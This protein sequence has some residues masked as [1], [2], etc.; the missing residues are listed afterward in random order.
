MYNIYSINGLI[1]SGDYIMDKILDNYLYDAFANASDNIFIYVTD[2]SQDLTRWSKKAVDFFGLEGEY[3]HG[4]K[5]MWLNQIHPDDRQV[6]IDDITAVFNGKTAQHNCQYRVRSR[7]GEYVWVECRGSLILDEN[8]TPAVFAGIMTRLD[9]QNKYDALTHLLTGYELLRSVIDKSGAVLLVGIDQFR[10]FNTRYGI[11]N[12]NKVLT[13]LGKMISEAA[14][15]AT[16]FHFHGDEFV[17]FAKEKTAADLQAIF[18]KICKMCKE[19]EENEG[20][21]SISLS[22]GIVEF[23]AGSYISDV[24]EKAELSLAFAKDD[25]NHIIVYSDEIGAKQT[26]KNTISEN[27]LRCIKNDFEGFSLVYQPI[28]NN[29]GDRV[30]ACE[31]LLRWNTNNPDIGPCYPGEFIPIL[32]GNGGII[33]VGYFVMREAIKQASKWQKEYKKFNVSFNVSYAQ[34]EDPQF[35]PEIIKTSKEYGVDTTGIVVE[36]TESILA[37][38]TVMVKQ[39]FKLLKEQGIQIA[40]D[41]FGTGNSSFWMLHN[42]D[43]DIVKLDQSF[44]RGLDESG[45]GIDY[46]IVESVG[47]MC[48]RI[49]CKTVAEGIETQM[50]WNSISR[51]EFEGLQGYLFS[52]PVNVAEFELLL[53]KYGMAL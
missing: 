9:N 12:G 6:Y 4:V 20:L 42:I 33:D 15:G 16:V 53:E 51:F 19:K 8:G 10:K 39:S 17:V 43:V 5:E 37:A 28:I 35:V 40:L 2:M 32:E 3:L 52:R 18:R 23:D 44:I 1:V 41:D 24:I 11:I 30:V 47:L 38:D 27:L 31:S 48:N 45:E 49:G 34:L 7:F 21:V 29:K 36:L 13:S 25:T 46:A 14:N 50:L 26:R 22:A